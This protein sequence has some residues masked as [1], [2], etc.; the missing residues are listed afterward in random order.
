MVY[1][2]TCMVDASQLCVIIDMVMMSRCE[3]STTTMEDG[4]WRTTCVT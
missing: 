4:A 2:W 1:T 3:T